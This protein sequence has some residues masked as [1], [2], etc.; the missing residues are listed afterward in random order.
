MVDSVNSSIKIL[1][2]GIINVQYLEPMIMLSSLS[3]YI[4]TLAKILMNPAVCNETNKK[5]ALFALQ[6]VVSTNLYNQYGDEV[7]WKEK[8]KLGTGA[9]IS[10]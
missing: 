4:Q 9:L 7:S 1:M 8:N 10:P 3:V 5:L 6:R 2:K